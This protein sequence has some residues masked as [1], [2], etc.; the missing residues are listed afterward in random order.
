MSRQLD[1]LAL[2]PFF[3]GIRRSMLETLVRT[4]RHRWMLLTLPPRRMERRLAAAAYWFAE[5]IARTAVGPFDLLFTCDA[6]NLADLYRLCPTVTD[7][8]SVVYFHCNQLPDPA[9]SDPESTLDLTHLT[10][11]TAA[12]QIWFN[13][14]F[15][16]R[17]FI[18]GIEGLVAGHKELQSRSPVQDLKSKLVHVPPPLDL[19]WAHELATQLGLDRDPNALFVETRDANIELLNSALQTLAAEKHPIN[20]WVT[21]PVDQLTDCFPRKVIAETDVSGQIRALLSAG[22]FVST[23]IAAPFDENAVRAMSLGCRPVLPHSGIYPEIVPH[24]L[25]S[26]CMYDLTAPSLAAHIHEAMYLLPMYRIDELSAR[27]KV[28][29]AIS[30]CA[31]IDERL[32]ALASQH[33]GAYLRTHRSDRHDSHRRPIPNL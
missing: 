22:A 30:A 12:S 21:G 29:D 19:V 3:G 17:S 14:Q 33:P 10:S 31:I 1:I 7:H 2:E 15:H 28:F 32:D 4:S 5:Q 8:P 9:S 20:L 27:L 23:K 16:A 18:A 11:A 6:L 13:S 26:E 25:H 24:N